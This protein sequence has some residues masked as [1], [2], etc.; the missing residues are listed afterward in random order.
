MEALNNNQLK[1]FS[2]TTELHHAG[3]NCRNMGLVRSVIPPDQLHSRMLLLIE[4]VRKK[5]RER[6]KGG[7]KEGKG[8]RKEGERREKGERRERERREGR[9]GR[10]GPATTGRKEEEGMEGA[11]QSDNGNRI[12][13]FF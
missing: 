1:K 5:G 8:G 10:R 4:M 11:K 6:E 2:V 9:G 3:I 13:R 7:R 12:F